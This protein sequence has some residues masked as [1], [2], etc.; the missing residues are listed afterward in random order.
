MDVDLSAKA[1][2]P[3]FAELYKSTVAQERRLTKNFRREQLSQGVL[4]AMFYSL[5]RI[6]YEQVT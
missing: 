5:G 6:T 3:R 1:G 2:D 4:D